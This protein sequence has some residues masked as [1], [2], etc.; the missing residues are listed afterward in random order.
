V[1]RAERLVE[2]GQ[3]DLYLREWGNAAPPVL[4]WHALGNHTNLQM[5]EAAPVLA[6][7]GYRVIGV[8]APGFGGSPP[9]EDEAYTAANLV[10]IAA[11]LLDALELDRVAWT[12]SSWGG[13]VGVHFAALHPERVAALALIDGGYLDPINEDGDTLE[14]LRAH[15]REQ[16]GFRFPTWDAALDDVRP[17]LAR[18]SPEIEEYVRSAFREEN[19]E[20][21]AILTP[22]VYAAAMHGIDRSPPSEVHPRLGETGIPVLLLGATEPPHEDAR[23]QL[24]AERFAADVPQAEV[25]RVPGAPHLMLEARPEETAR[26]IAGWLKSLPYA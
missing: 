26:A 4:F 11:D 2:A 14:E 5:I 22:D 7:E 8:D 24:W 9:L 20:V 13:I 18:W 16:D 15:W 23:R 21:V 3:T 6:D 19:G 1:K 10:K 12:G 25:R 17:W